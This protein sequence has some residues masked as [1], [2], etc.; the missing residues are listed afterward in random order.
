MF[1]I[2]CGSM[3]PEDASFCSSCG[4]A[5][6]ALGNPS[7]V[8]EPPER[9]LS[10]AEKPSGNAIGQT[11]RA[12]VLPAQPAPQPSAEYLPATAGKGKPFLWVLAGFAAC[13]L[14]MVT[15]ALG[16]RLNRT[17]SGPGPA[18]DN[19]VS[20]APPT[21]AP[22]TYTVPATAAPA[23]PTPAPA[24]APVQAPPQP[25]PAA[26]QNPIV[27]D[28]KATTFIGSS[29]ELHFGADGQYTLKDA[30]DSEKGVY[31][32]SSGDGTLRLQ[33]NAVFSH[34]IVIWNCQL[35]GDS[36]SCVDPNGAGHVYS[37]Q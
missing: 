1:C 26:P 7:T 35:S 16:F 8:A 6:D 36:L 23:D 10:S 19:Q 17:S 28:W 30:L 34:D 24:N 2:H 33:P 15:V 9:I 3:N 27:G 25:A 14:I 31:V 32:F 37:R 29:I 12:I 18:P 13:L 11:S 21:A 22:A 4:K 20:D 5:I